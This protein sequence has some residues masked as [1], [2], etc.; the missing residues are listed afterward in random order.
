MC[1]Y[2]LCLVWESQLKSAFKDS[3]R[4]YMR[5]LEHIC[6]QACQF[7]VSS[8]YSISSEWGKKMWKEKRMLHYTLEEEV[9]QSW[10]VLCTSDTLQTRKG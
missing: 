1:L 3:V 2:L 5:Y 9:W 8:D 7:T 6:W 4:V 10:G